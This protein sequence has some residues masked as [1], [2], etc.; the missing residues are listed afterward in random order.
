MPLHIILR[1]AG[2]VASMVIGYIYNSKIYTRTQVL[3]VGL[4]TVGVVAAAL[5]DAEAQGKSLDIG[6]STDTDASSF[7]TFLTGFMILA[8]AMILSAFQGVYADR[9]YEVHGRSHWKEAL[10]YSHMISLPFLLPTYPKLATQLRALLNS[11]PALSTLATTA[12]VDNLFHPNSTLTALTSSS[13]ASPFSSPPTHTIPSFLLPLSKIPIFHSILSQTPIQVIY[14][15]VNA[16]T[17][18][19]CIRGVHLLSAQSSSLTVTIV[20]NIRKLASLILSIYIFGNVL[21]TGVLVG[22][23]V[24]FVGGGIYGFEGA[25]LRKKKVKEK[26]G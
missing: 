26:S 15:V 1:S 13:T 22:A 6:L 10:F 3:A 21:A 7:A 23:V 17:Q 24:V 9:L 19:V 5:A 14:L 11:P 8:L 4:L 16:L 12:N 20:L 18:Y 25:R 2:P